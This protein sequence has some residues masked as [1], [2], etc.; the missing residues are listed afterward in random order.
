MFKFMLLATLIPAAVFGAGFNIIPCP[1]IPLPTHF[2]IPECPNGSPCDFRI[3]QTITLVISFQANTAVQSIPT[4]AEITRYNGEVHNF[5]LPSGDACNAISGGC[6][7]GPGELTVRFP[8]VV[9]GILP[10]EQ[11][12]ITVTMRD[13]NNAGLTCGSIVAMFHPTN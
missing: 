11:V 4:L 6:P 10:D 8:V 1:G 9:G 12:T 13:Q 7:A 5:P 3:G 2:D